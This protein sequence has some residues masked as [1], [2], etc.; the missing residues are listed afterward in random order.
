[1]AVHKGKSLIS[2]I[3][4]CCFFLKK[5]KL[6]TNLNTGMSRIVIPSGKHLLTEVFLLV[7]LN[8]S[9]IA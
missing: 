3:F 5:I 7:K 2:L 9:E 4:K 8:C 1:M 6:L